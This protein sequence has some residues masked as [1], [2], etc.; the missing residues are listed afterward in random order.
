MVGRK[1]VV[2]VSRA[3]LFVALTVLLSCGEKGEKGKNGIIT[4]YVVAEQKA[5]LAPPD[6]LMPLGNGNEVKPVPGAKVKVESVEVKKEGKAD[7]NGKFEIEVPRGHYNLIAEMVRQDGKKFN[8]LIEVDVEESKVVE[9]G[10]VVIKEAGAI[11]GVARLSDK[12]PGYYKGIVV[13]IMAT[14][15]FALT[16]ENGAYALPGVPSGTYTLRFDMVGYKEKE[17]EG[18]VVESGKATKVD[19]VI[20]DVD[21]QEIINKGIVGGTVKDAQ[22][23]SPIS[24]ALISVKGLGVSSV[25]LDD[26]SYQIAI[27]PG[28]YK[29]LAV[30]DG[31]GMAEIEV[32]VLAGETIQADIILNPS[33][34]YGI[35][36]LKGKVI[37]GTNG[38]P[39]FS[40][41]VLSNPSRGQTYTD[42]NGTFSLNL[43]VGCYTI[44]FAKGGYE[45]TKI[46]VCLDSGMKVDLGNI[47]L[48]PSGGGCFAETEVCDGKDNDCDGEVDEGCGG[49]TTPPETTIT[50]YP[51]NP[52][53]S[54]SATF[55]F[56]CNEQNCTFECQIDGGSW[57]TCTSPKTYTNLS[58][59]SH[60]FSVRAKDSAGNIDPTP[61]SYS[62]KI[63][64]P[65]TKPRAGVDISYSNFYP[66]GSLRNVS[67]GNLNL[68]WSISNVKD[69]DITTGDI[70]HDGKIEIV[71][72]DNPNRHLKAFSY[73]G[74]LLWD[75]DLSSKSEALSGN[76]LEDV[77]GD[78]IPEILVG[79]RDTNDI[80]KVD[81]YKGD[82]SYIKTLNAGQGGYDSICAP[83]MVKGD[84]VFI[85]CDAGYSCSPRGLKALSYSTGN[86]VWEY[87][88]GPAQWGNWYSVGDIGKDGVLDISIPSGTPHNGCYGQDTNDDQLYSIVVKEDG[89]R[90]FSTLLSTLEGVSHIDG[91][92]SQK[93]I[94]LNGDGNP[95]VIGFEGHN[96]PYYPGTNKILLINSSGTAIIRT[97]NGPSNGNVWNSSIADING[98]G[99]KEIV[100]STHYAGTDPGSKENIYIISYD[101]TSTLYQSA[102]AGVVLGTNDIDGDGQIEIIV[103]QNSTKK[104]R[105]LNPD[106]T[107]QWSYQLGTAEVGWDASPYNFAISDLDGNGINEI[108]IAPGVSTADSLYVLEPQ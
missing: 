33:S 23:S 94:D 32:K 93:L 5:G 8:A 61:V 15:M 107:E 36:T 3:F 13:Y 26:G 48:Y 52:T 65:Q 9:V 59:G 82:G 88:K 40:A 66:N 22:T 77:T 83:F 29:L 45:E 21:E 100:A 27:D 34:E 75:I 25:S 73:N 91:S 4:G 47:A 49:D 10:Q 95:E 17:V 60:T 76:L 42:T 108:I 51:Q 105:V 31:Y 92:Y 7:E 86:V 106:L 79:Y 102:G 16:D 69:W 6:T 87:I 24:G 19:D 56:T 28:T 38:N 90:L 101:L 18:I 96:V 46:S 103:L 63:I 104:I 41:V 12:S 89:T 54:T 30:A 72:V 84:R 98:D 11:Y 71:A 64:F 55:A 97:W 44:T 67:T 80:I 57:E 99:K 53:N 78:G 39:V 2:N 43:P 68:K 1:T 58:E 74:T 50:S 62:W 70:N 81:V 35:A 85:S 37:D 14:G 20:L